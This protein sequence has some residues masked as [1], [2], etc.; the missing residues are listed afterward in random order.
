MCNH[1]VAMEITRT[2][3]L[4]TPADE[5]WRLLTDPDE[6]AGWVG[7]EIRSAPVT[8]DGHH[9]RLTWTWAPDGVESEVEV[10]VV[11]VGDRTQVQVVERSAGR[12]SASARAC[13]LRRWDDALFALEWRAVTWTHRLV[14][15]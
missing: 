4:D 15:V 6:L 11:E 12:P 3:D 7:E 10:A 1:A 5:V 14:G 13:S 9:R 8:S 2:L